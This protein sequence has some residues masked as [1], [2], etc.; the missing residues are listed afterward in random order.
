M[1]GNRDEVY[2]FPLKLNPIISARLGKI[3]FCGEVMVDEID[4]DIWNGDFLDR[5]QDAVIL[6]RF[7]IGQLELQQE[8]GNSSTYVLNLDSQWGGG[9]TFFLKRFKRD[10]EQQGHVVVYVDAWTSDHA[11]DPLIAVFSEIKDQIEQVAETNN[12]HCKIID[13]IERAKRSVEKIVTKTSVGVMKQLVRKYAG[14]ELLIELGEG[15]ADTLGDEVIGAFKE[16]TSSIEAFKAGLT[17]LLQTVVVEAKK[18]TPVFVLIDE[19]DRCR[20]SYAISLLERVK[21]LF[22]VEGVIFV[23][24]TDTQQLGYAVSGTYGSNFN[25]SR[26]LK[27]FFDRTYRFQPASIEQFV[28]EQFR[29]LGLSEDDFEA[30]PGKTVVDFCTETFPMAEIQLRDVKRMMEKLQTFKAI[31]KYPKLKIQLAY[32]LPLIHED[33]IVGESE[34]ENISKIRECRSQAKWSDTNSSQDRS[35]EYVVKDFIK[36]VDQHGND[37]FEYCKSRNQPSLQ[38]WIQSVF[39]QEMEIVHGSSFNKSKCPASVLFSYPTL[40]RQIASF[41]ELNEEVF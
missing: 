31:W 14:D 18:K 29:E 13:R 32:L 40:L 4:Q 41:D 33:H 19:L 39:R 3:H 34:E 30:M 22:S 16:K 17:K 7:L 10:L 26:Y 1:S 25:G 37:I 2:P 11:D 36:E 15:I 28:K 20:P 6:H 5:K 24:A 9:K 23:I 21:H 27:R 12:V 35:I 8:K 38:D